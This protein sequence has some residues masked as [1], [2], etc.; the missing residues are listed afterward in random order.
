MGA[1]TVADSHGDE[2]KSIALLG[3]F[4]TCQ[5]TSPDT[6]KPVAS[7]TDCVVYIAPA[8]EHITTITIDEYITSNTTSTESKATWTV[9]LPAYAPMGLS[10]DRPHQPRMLK[11][12]IRHQP[13]I[14][15]RRRHLA[16]GPARPM[17]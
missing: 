5:G 13:T 12:R 11:D 3:D 14:G 6:L 10:A 1:L 4:P 15:D 8:G 17:A 9:H 7:F 16:G 2:V